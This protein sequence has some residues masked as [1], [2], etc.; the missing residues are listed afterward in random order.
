[1]DV[2]ATEIPDVKIVQLD[3]YRDERGFFME[4]WRDSWADALGLQQRF[5]QD[6]FSRSVQHTLRGLHY[7]VEKPQAKLVRVTTGR[8]FDVA[9]DLR[10]ASPT[11][12]KWVG[13]EL[14]AENGR[15]LFIPVGFAH[16]FY[17]LSK[18]AEYSYKCTDYYYPSGDRT[19]K[20]DDKT[21]NISWPIER[22]DKLVVS[23][24]DSAGLP[25]G[26]CTVF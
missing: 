14:S 15:M 11:F 19:L 24:K 10:R 17:V 2:V 18:L 16:G 3:V 25:L 22:Y 13:A 23:D 1:M 21:I 4:S 8:V 12:G 6:N 20:W 26:D 9:V 7:Q 5:V